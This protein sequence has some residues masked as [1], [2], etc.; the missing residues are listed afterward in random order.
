[1]RLAFSIFSFKDKIR[2]KLVAKENYFYLLLISV[3]R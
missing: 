1:M 2:T 3:A